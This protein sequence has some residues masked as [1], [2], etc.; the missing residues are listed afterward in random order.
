MAISFLHAPARMPRSIACSCAQGNFGT[1][2]W[3]STDSLFPQYRRSVDPPVHCTCTSPWKKKTSASHT[4]TRRD[5]AEDLLLQVCVTL[6]LSLEFFHPLKLHRNKCSV[7]VNMDW[8]VLVHRNAMQHN[9]TQLHTRSHNTMQQSRAA[10]PHPQHDASPPDA[11]QLHHI[12]QCNA[13]SVPST[14]HHTTPHHTTQCI[15][16]Q[17]PTA[18][19]DTGCSSQQSSTRRISC[20]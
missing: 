15:R 1:A 16:M 6:I 12:T 4:A 2:Q 10:I 11:I 7:T 5:G 3:Y 17:C 13:I 19:P 20:Y 14:P 18:Q 8:G 9:T